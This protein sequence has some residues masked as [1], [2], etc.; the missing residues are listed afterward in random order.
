[1]SRAQ[2]F[3]MLGIAAVLAI[4]AFLV[5]RPAEQPTQ[6]AENSAAER[7]SSERA[8]GSNRAEPRPEPPSAAAVVIRTKGGEP[9]GEVR[10]L[11]VESGD[12]VMLEVRS[13][14]P[15]EVHVHGYDR[16]IPVGPDRSGRA[17]FK[18]N[19]EGI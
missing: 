4:A 1:M 7:P 12:T 18:A 15:E 5:L 8:A 9:V 10:D 6:R 19:L 16:Y 17:R 3:T 14:V 2:R 11:T 13:D